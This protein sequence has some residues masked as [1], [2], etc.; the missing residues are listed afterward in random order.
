MTGGGLTIHGTKENHYAECTNA[1]GVFMAI[2]FQDYKER[3]SKRKDP[4]I[5]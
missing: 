5:H 3:I 4:Y 1:Q 2:P